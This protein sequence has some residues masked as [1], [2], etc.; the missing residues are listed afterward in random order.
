M[1]T[2]FDGV[3]SMAKKHHTTLRNAAYILAARR[4]AEAEVRKN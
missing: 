2:A 1:K 4:I 3:L